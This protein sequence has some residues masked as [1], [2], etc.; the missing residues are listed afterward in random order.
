[1]GDG[2]ILSGRRGG[3]RASGGV[4]GQWLGAWR[5]VY[6]LVADDALTADATTI[7]RTEDLLLDEDRTRA[8]LEDLVAP[9]RRRKLLTIRG[10]ERGF[11]VDASHAFVRLSVEL[12]SA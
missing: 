1:M 6:G 8:A 10:A 4:V 3:R 7:F 11:A 2:S 5:R 9:R 12:T